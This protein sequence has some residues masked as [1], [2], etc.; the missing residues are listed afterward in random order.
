VI[1]QRADPPAR[2]A[3]P[4]LGPYA[5]A[6]PAK[7]P[8]G[9]ARPEIEGSTTSLIVP[10]L[11]PCQPVWQPGQA[12][13]AAAGGAGQRR[14]R[15]GVAAP[16]PEGP[17]THRR[18]RSGTRTAPLQGNPRSPKDCHQSKYVQTLKALTCRFAPLAGLEP[19]PYG[20]EV[21]HEPST[22]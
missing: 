21:R 14:G 12:E 15:A 16:L 11:M 1:G 6:R 5:T 19:A 4:H 22:W 9:S 10:V 17:C 20:L 8:V 7:T 13:I 2:Q 18:F 3:D